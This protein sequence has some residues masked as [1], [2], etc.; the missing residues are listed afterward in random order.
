MAVIDSSGA[1][2]ELWD[3]VSYVVRIHNGVYIMHVVHVAYVVW[4]LCLALCVLYCVVLYVLC[5][6]C[7]KS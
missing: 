1:A 6:W 4:V 2:P 7:D 3:R 5:V